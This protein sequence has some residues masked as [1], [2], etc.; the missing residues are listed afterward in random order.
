M[1]VTGP[2]AFD[3]KQGD[4]KG[5]AF[6]RLVSSFIRSPSEEQAECQRPK[7]ILLDTGEINIP[8]A[9]SVPLYP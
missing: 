3:F 7:Q 4:T 8:Y 1:A 2:G 6:W 5:T 9:W